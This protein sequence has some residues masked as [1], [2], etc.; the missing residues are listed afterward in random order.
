MSLVTNAK[1]VEELDIALLEVDSLLESV[2]CVYYGNNQIGVFKPATHD[3][4]FALQRAAYIESELMGDESEWTRLSRQIVPPLKDYS[5]HNLYPFEGKMHPQLARALI[6][7]CAGPRSEA[8][9]LDPFCGS[10]TILLEANLLG[11]LPYGSDI[12]PL[13]V[14]L[15]DAKTAPLAEFED[16]ISKI[17]CA[18]PTCSFSNLIE[19]RKRVAPQFSGHASIID[20]FT[21]KI[22]QGRGSYHA[23]VTSPPYFNAID[24]ASRFTTLRSALKLPKPAG[25]IGVGQSVEQYE[26]CV[27]RIGQNIAQ[28]LLP[29]GRAAIVIADHENVPS[30]EWYELAMKTAGL[31]RVAKLKHI[32]PAVRRGLSFEWI[33]IM[34]KPVGENTNH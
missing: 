9:L 14:F 1:T 7:I 2:G 18:D 32:Y 28:L 23:I 6:N 30:S 26:S 3:E 20:D 17:A 16:A 24:Y 4:S 29:G 27:E 10:G 13:A 19:S 21:E 15:S 25:G 5:T 34:E 31:R 11:H 33:L 22:E 12:D 8:L